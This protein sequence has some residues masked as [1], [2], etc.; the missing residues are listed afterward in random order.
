MYKRKVQP[1]EAGILFHSA[2]LTTSRLASRWNSSIAPYSHRWAVESRGRNLVKRRPDN[3]SA[4]GATRH[5]AGWRRGSPAKGGRRAQFAAGSR[6]PPRSRL[7]NAAAHPETTLHLL[8]VR[9]GQRVEKVGVEIFL[10]PLLGA[11]HKIRQHNG[12]VLRPR[13]LSAGQQQS[14][15]AKRVRDIIFGVTW[16]SFNGWQT[17]RANQFFQPSFTGFRH[18]P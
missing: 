14:E 2:T 18:D 6:H 8:L 3:P 5:R 13:Q 9:R 10:R 7:E 12:V 11:L 17:R 1:I 15:Q 16:L 4:P